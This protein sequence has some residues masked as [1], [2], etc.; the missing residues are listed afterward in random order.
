MVLF[1]GLHKTPLL[2]FTALFVA[3]W[4]GA[5]ATNAPATIRARTDV[6]ITLRYM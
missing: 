4:D 5:T 3:A 6:V 1:A 2:I